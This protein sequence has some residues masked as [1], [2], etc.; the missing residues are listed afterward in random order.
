MAL[1][2]HRERFLGTEGQ[3]SGFV[4]GFVSMSLSKPEIEIQTVGVLNTRFS[5]G[6]YCKTICFAEVEFQCLLVDLGLASMIFGA[7]DTALKFYD[8]PWP[9]GCAPEIR[10]DR[11]WVVRGWLWV[12]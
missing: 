4:I 9:P 5:Y 10:V 6:M 11:K 3:K 1:G 2:L 7:L 8:F 12:H